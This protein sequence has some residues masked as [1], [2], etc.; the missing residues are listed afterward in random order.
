MTILKKHNTLL[1]LT[2]FLFTFSI[3]FSLSLKYRMSSIN[4]NEVPYI[5]T[6]Y[7]TPIVAP[8]EDVIINFYI[9]DYNHT[10]YLT[11]KSYNN[12]TVTININNKKNIV[13]KNL[14]SGDNSINLGKFNTIGEQNFSIKC[15]DKYGRNS[16]ELFN[17]FLVKNNSYFN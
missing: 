5:S 15:T 9:T 13:K 14:K 17:F 12:F 11:E 16:H 8:N 2:L 3:F 4:P 7:I 10:E 1:L 6:Y